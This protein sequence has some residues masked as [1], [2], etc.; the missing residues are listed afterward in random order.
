[1]INPLSTSST[2]TANAAQALVQQLARRVDVNHDGAVTKPEF[3]QF[4]ASLV[5]S[6]NSAS[7]S[8]TPASA[9]ATVDS[10]FQLGARRLAASPAGL[11]TMSDLDPAASVR[12]ANV[13]QITKYLTQALSV[14]TGS[15]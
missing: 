5:E 3:E 7:T 11:S 2:S 6:L 10:P 14:G 4:V 13:E 9:G 15:R 1:M 12:R 8:A